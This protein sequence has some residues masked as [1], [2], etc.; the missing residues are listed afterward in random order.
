[1][2]DWARRSLEGCPIV[3]LEISALSTT[4]SPRRSGEDESHIENLA[5]WGEELPPIVVHEPSMRV[6]DGVHRLRAAVLRGDR[7]IRARCYQGSE[8]D[9][10]VL[11][12]WM[13]TA[14]GLPLS[15]QDRTEAAI[16]ILKTHAHWSDRRIAAAVGLAAGTIRSLRR[17]STDQNA[18]SDIRIGRDGRRRPLNSAAGR[19]LASKLLIEN[20]TASLRA[21]ARQAGVSPATV[22]DVRK[23]MRA[24]DDPV[25]EPRRGHSRRARAAVPLRRDD[26]SSGRRSWQ[27]LAHDLKH[28]LDQMK[29][30]PAL[31]FTETGRNLLRWLDRHVLGMAEWPQLLASVPSHCTVLVANFA[32]LYGAAWTSLATLLEEGEITQ[33]PNLEIAGS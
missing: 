17:R 7:H 28:A 20:P 12:V 10:F 6:I 16:R 29:K 14:H 31:R 33:H 11:S 18:Q 2:A 22:Q 21:V 3:T 26:G 25:P 5:E 27:T 8:E 24:G 30:D 32:R 4:E 23:R 9:A 19:R 13:N 15:R 1:M